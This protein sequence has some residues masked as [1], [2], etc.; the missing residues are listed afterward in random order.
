M[1][2]LETLR[3]SRVEVFESRPLTASPMSTLS[4]IIG[5]LEKNDA[6]E[7]FIEDGDKVGVVSIRDILRTSNIL[8][9]RAS[10]LMT[11]IH[12]LSPNDPVERAAA[13][14]SD[15]R[16]RASPVGETKIDGT[17]TTQSLCRALLP[18]KEFG[19]IKI[20]KLTKKDPITIG[21]SE[22]TSKARSVMV[23]HTID[24]LPVMDSG[25]VGGI[26]LSNQIVLSMFPKERREQ[27]TLSGEATKY[28]NIRASELMDMNIL[29]CEPNEKASDV[30]K[31]MIEQEKTYAL[32]K[33]WDELQG[34][35]TYRDFVALLVE[36]EKPDFPAYI[37]GLPDDPF[38]AQLARARFFKE[39]KALRRSFP[40]IEEIRATIKTKNLPSGR[41]RYE[42]S[43]SIETHGKVHAYSMEGWDLPM[44]FEGLQG[45]MK[46]ILTQRRDKRKRGSTRKSFL[47]KQRARSGGSPVI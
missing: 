12:K 7:V 31:R 28:S 47:A 11:V 38:E 2:N 16:L 37:V 25:K 20:D 8:G 9:A 13:F 45:K 36:S 23:E 29:V 43:V 30:L 40:D 35:V 22:S 6:Y 46:R 14:M 39:A 4:E 19:S 26:L 32:M 15:Y 27:G 44:A 5:T 42:I 17:V 10:S 41:H 33:Q 1:I 3:K 18:I 24:H 34:I 21:K